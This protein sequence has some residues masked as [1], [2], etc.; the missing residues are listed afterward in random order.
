MNKLK[1]LNYK[2]WIDNSLTFLAPLV[3]MYLLNAQ[4]LVTKDGFQA[5]DFYL[6]DKMMGAMI[7][8]I[9]NIALDFFKK[10]K[11]AN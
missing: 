10:Y 5:S 8:Y 4:S 6:D 11:Q 1:T 3:I 7:L 2:K 9:I